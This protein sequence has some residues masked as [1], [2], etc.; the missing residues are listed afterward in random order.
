M[1]RK[2]YLCIISYAIAMIISFLPLALP[3]QLKV[4]AIGPVRGV[5]VSGGLAPPAGLLVDTGNINL[6]TEAGAFQV[7]G[8]NVLWNNGIAGC[9]YVGGSGSSGSTGI[10]NTFLGNSSGRSNTYGMGNTF[11]G[12]KA[13]YNN[14]S[15]S[16]NIFSGDS[17]GYYNTAGNNNTISGSEAGRGLPGYS[18]SENTFYG[19]K[20]GYSTKSHY[21]T[22]IGAYSGYSNQGSLYNTFV[23]YGSGYDNN[24]SGNTY[25]TFVGHASGRYNKNGR[26]N[27]FYGFKSGFNT[28]SGSDNA[29]IGLQA[30]EGNVSGNYNVAVGNYSGDSFSSGDSCTFIGFKADKSSAYTNCGAIGFGAI[31]NANRKIVIGHTNFASSQG[32]IGGYV[33]WSVLSDGR[34]KVNIKEEVKG[35]EFIKKLRPVT[36]QLDMQKLDLFLDKSNNSLPDSLREGKNQNTDSSPRLSTVHTG[37]IAQEVEKA[38]AEC[39]Y[40]F[41]GIHFPNDGNDNYSLAYAS[42][43][44]PLVKAVQELSAGMDSIRKSNSTT[45]MQKTDSLIQRIQQ[46]ESRVNG[47]CR[48]MQ[49]PTDTAGQKFTDTIIPVELISSDQPI[50]YQN[51]PNPFSDETTINYYLPETIKNASMF[52]YDNTGRVIKEVELNLKGAGTLAVNSSK[53]AQGIYAYS[54]SVEGKVISTYKMLKVK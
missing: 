50:L 3:A 11:S 48:N 13:G 9:I 45:L 28:L 1:N 29:Y 26:F 25:N 51:I 44:V 42:F 39:D 49:L 33:Q 53:L 35:L 14:L 7:K 21:N 43:V 2:I 30:G 54:L 12:H 5:A 31:T 16:N 38:A 41:D 15:G 37:F 17:A 40:G 47:C 46:L 6:G 27:S 22:F 52:F 19:Y 4:S 34:F 24:N 8:M 32:V 20:A 18:Y 36:Y 10:N 23:G